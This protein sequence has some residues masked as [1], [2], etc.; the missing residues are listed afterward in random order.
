MVLQLITNN[1]FHYKHIQELT[2]HS[3][4]VR[5]SPQTDKVIMSKVLHFLWETF[6]SATEFAISPCR[7]R[8]NRCESHALYMMCIRWEGE[9]SHL[10]MFYISALA[11]KC[12][13]PFRLVFRWW[14]FLGQLCSFPTHMAKTMNDSQIERKGQTKRRRQSAMGYN[15]LKANRKGWTRMRYK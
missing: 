8:S 14:F 10:H 11:S 13:L 5:H 1:V 2:L 15:F 9:F 4:T 7:Y 12:G 3:A 6:Q